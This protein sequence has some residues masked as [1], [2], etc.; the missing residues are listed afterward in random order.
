MEMKRINVEALFGALYEQV[1]NA[2]NG[3]EVKD[4]VLNDYAEED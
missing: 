2:R 3:K 1:D 4:V